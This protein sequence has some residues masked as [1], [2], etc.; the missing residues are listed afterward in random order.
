MCVN[1]RKIGKGF[2]K[3]RF[4]ELIACISFTRQKE[5]RE[6]VYAGEAMSVRRREL[7]TEFGQ[8]L[9]GER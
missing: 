2:M 4:L 8:G 5:Y 6:K 1:L 3:G 9:E 7:F